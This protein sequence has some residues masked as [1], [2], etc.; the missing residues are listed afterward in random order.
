MDPTESQLH[1]MV[2]A[3]TGQAFEPVIPV[4]LQ[5]TAELREMRGRTNATAILGIN[6]GGSRMRWAAPRPVIDGIAP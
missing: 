3:I 1:R 6:I 5:N 4:N 2:S